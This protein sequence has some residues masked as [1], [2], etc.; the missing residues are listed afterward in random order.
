M[1]IRLKILDVIY[2]SV[3]LIFCG[4]C[5]QTILSG[6]GSLGIWI[7]MLSLFFKTLHLIFTNRFVPN[8]TKQN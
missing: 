4:I 3:S 5:V 8:T 6:K 7:V 2:L 1:Q